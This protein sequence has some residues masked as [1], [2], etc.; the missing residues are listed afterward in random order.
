MGNYLHIQGRGGRKRRIRKALRKLKDMQERLQLDAEQALIERHPSLPPNTTISVKAII[1]ISDEALYDAAREAFYAL[2]VF[3]PKP[4]TFSEEAAI[5]VSAKSAEVLDTLNDYG[6]LESSGLER[7]T[8]HQTIANYAELMCTDESLEPIYQRMVS[9]F[10]NYI[11]NYKTKYNVLEQEINNVLAALDVAFTEAMGNQLVQGTNSFCHFLEIR[12]F[13][14]LAE[15]LLKRAERAALILDCSTPLIT[16]WLNLGTL[17]IQLGRYQEAWGKLNQAD[18]EVRRLDDEIEMAIVNVHLSRFYLNFNFFPEVLKLI[19]R[20]CLV[21][22][23]RGMKKDMA[24]AEFYLA[25]AYRQI[26]HKREAELLFQKIRSF[27]TVDKDPVWAAQ[28]DLQRAILLREADRQPEAILLIEQAIK[29]FVTHKFTVKAAQARLLLAECYYDLQQIEQA[30]SL[31]EA[32]IKIPNELRLSTLIYRAYYGLGRVAEV[33]GQPNR[34]FDFYQAA[35]KEIEAIRQNLQVDEFKA[36][37][38]D[39][40][41]ALYQAAVRLGVETRQLFKA[42]DYV[43][44][45]KSST[46]SDLLARN[47]QLRTE[48]ADMVDQEAWQRLRGLKKKLR[49][50]HQKLQEPPV[51]EKQAHSV[52]VTPDEAWK[53][54]GRIEVEL[55]QLWRQLQGHRVQSLSAEAKHAWKILN[56]EIESETILVEYFFIEDEM[57][58]F[59]LTSENNSKELSVQVIQSFPYSRQEIERSLR[60]VELALKKVSALSLKYINKILTP[61]AL[62]HLNWL[63]EALIAP[64]MPTLKEYSKVII[65]SDDLLYALPFHALYDGQQYLIDY[66]EIHYAPSASVLALCHQ[67]KNRQQANTVPKP[68]HEVLLMGYSHDGELSGVSNEVQTIAAT[69]SSALLFEEQNATVANLRQ[70]ASDC[71]VLHLASHAIFHED[72]PL[73]SSL[74]LADEPLNVIDIYQLELNASLVTLSGSETGINKL[75]GGDLFGLARGFLNAGAPALVASLSRVDDASTVLLMQK[76][77]QHLQAGEPIARALRAAQLAL[78]E[79]EEEQDGELVRPYDHPY[80]W[81]PFFLMGADGVI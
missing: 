53:E 63:Y 14:K 66:F 26:G 38:L 47:L 76:F 29:L 28:I 67:T 22:E 11:E 25:T 24:E 30:R 74:L 48:D 8:L 18:K 54:L 9:F 6:L 78:R 20:A 35:I 16:T 34:A 36:S 10:V 3:P 5:A 81:A 51:E 70:H 40:K 44:Q 42:F 77:Y 75:T 57:M 12:G 58:A 72:N 62:R 73:F 15:A 23:Q 69:F 1:A 27:F 79:I 61:L 55:N 31:Y 46:L 43:E 45:A 37:F 59:L 50:Q 68:T 49:W 80:Y 4:N 13:Y 71:G 41:L 52:S 65:V 17:F 56:Q 60:T 64:L 7:Y 32:V 21:F 39:N 19:K 33:Q 2:S